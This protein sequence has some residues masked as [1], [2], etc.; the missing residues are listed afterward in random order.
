MNGEEIVPTMT[1]GAMG[2][3]GD[4]FPPVRKVTFGPVGD[5]TLH[6]A[7][8]PLLLTVKAAVVWSTRHRQQLLGS[9]EVEDDTTDDG[10]SVQAMEKYLAWADQLHRHKS[11]E[12]VA[13]GLGQRNGYLATTADA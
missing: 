10:L 4:N 3:D 13:A 1:K 2:E 11:T 9:D 5:T 6:P 7:P 12:D 8:D